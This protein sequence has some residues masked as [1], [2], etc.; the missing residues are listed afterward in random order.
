MTNPSYA[1]DSPIADRAIWAKTT[2]YR[3]PRRD[4]ITCIVLHSAETP[5]LPT[6]A[7]GVG[8]YFAA[9]SGGRDASAHWI[10][11]NDSTVQSVPEDAEAFGA[12]G[13]NPWAIHIEQAGTAKQSS[14]QW[15]D[16]YSHAMITAKTIPLVADICRRRG[17]A[18]RLLTVERL[19]AGERN[20][21]TTHGIT[22]LW[23]RATNMPTNGHTDPGPNYPLQFVVDEVAKLVN[24]APPIVIPTSI[25][26]PPSVP[27]AIDQL[28]IL[29]PATLTA[30]HAVEVFNAHRS[31]GANGY[32]KADI[33]KIVNA[34]WAT[35]RLAGIR[36]EVILGQIV[37]ETSWLTS[38]FSAR[39]QRNPAGIG[40]TGASYATQD[41]AGGKPVA[42]DPSVQRWRLGNSF[43]QWAADV[44]NIVSA[45]DAH[46]G[47]LAAYAIK[48][49][50]GNVEQKRL[51][52]IALGVR[53][54]PDILRGCAVTLRDLA[55][56]DNPNHV[57]WAAVTGY[58]ARVG[59]QA[60]L[61][62]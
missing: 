14:T 61:F 56:P 57:G 44:P 3:R 15:N 6:S 60:K 46:V 39:P 28:T 53:P 36:L 45:V 12:Q 23:R 38:F 32:T 31:D 4:K 47:R 37:Q 10:V 55:I 41:Q 29:G 62:M 16:T 11:D 35:A 59:A 13:T 48:K 33:E 22:T 1:V 21:I 19:L 26:V 40:V 43:G 24:V 7:E 9:G 18:V 17:I 51:I 49:D 8:N 27:S 5:E 2:V 30:A 34:Y 58:G 50:D 25:N 54:L 52:N 20:G 42:Y